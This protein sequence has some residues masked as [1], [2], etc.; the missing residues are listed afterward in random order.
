MIYKVLLEG[1]VTCND[2]RTPLHYTNK[3]HRLGIYKLYNKNIIFTE[4]K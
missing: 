4:T 1:S 2:L 3:H